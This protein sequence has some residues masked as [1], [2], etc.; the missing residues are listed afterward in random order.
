MKNKILKAY[1]NFA[2]CGLRPYGFS[3][4]EVNPRATYLLARTKKY[5]ELFNRSNYIFIGIAG[6]E[7]IY[8]SAK[9][10]QYEGLL[11]DGGISYYMLTSEHELLGCY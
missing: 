6:L 5:D 1:D 3:Y 7:S 11:K 8:D 9:S 4:K 2:D 10:E